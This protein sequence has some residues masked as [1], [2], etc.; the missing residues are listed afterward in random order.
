MSS[1][2]PL[3]IVAAIVLAVPA[4][5]RS[6][7]VVGNAGYFSEW[8][9]NG[10]VTE[11]VSAGGNEFFGPLIWRHVGVCNVNG[12]LEKFGEIT[13]RLSGLKASRIDAIILMD[14]SQCVYSGDLSASSAG[15]M[16]CS[17]AK[18]IPLSISVK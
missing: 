8:E 4:Q 14:R 7:H 6:L 1:F 3:I 13:F 5:S 17:N 16:D 18:G 10:T 9:F 12:P 2:R 11:N 15:H